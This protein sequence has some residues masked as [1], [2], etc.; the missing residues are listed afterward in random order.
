MRFGPSGLWL[1]PPQ[2]QRSPQAFVR[3]C[4]GL[5][6]GQ[7]TSKGRNRAPER[8]PS[9]PGWSWSGAQTPTQARTPQITRPQ[10]SGH[11]R[12][13]VGLWSCTVAT[14][15]PPVHPGHSFH[16]AVARRLRRS[17]GAHRTGYSPVTCGL[18]RT[19]WLHG[20]WDGGRGRGATRSLGAPPRLWSR[21]N[22]LSCAHSIEICV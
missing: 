16:V 2:T 10:S 15:P 8:K 17:P 18:H 6:H 9:P 22:P 21:W 3:T 12:P 20:D 11:G 19:P 1:V 5:A 4:A 14:A 13:G 7:A